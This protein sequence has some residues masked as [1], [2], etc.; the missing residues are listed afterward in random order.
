MAGAEDIRWPDYRRSCP[1]S[2]WHRT[3]ATFV[4]AE[5]FRFGIYTSPA[6]LACSGRVGSAG[7]VAADARTFAHW[8]V[9]YVKLDW[10]GSD[11][12]PSGAAAIAR[13]WRAA[14]SAT[15]RPMILASTPAGLHPSG[16]GPRD[17][18][19]LASRR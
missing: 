1:L 14:L 4:H 9:D 8:G 5:G 3:A 17:C 6:P 19:Q 18:E 11:Y 15:G 16:V 7:H 10:C 13:T 2:V 12:S